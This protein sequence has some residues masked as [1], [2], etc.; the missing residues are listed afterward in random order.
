MK[1]STH[2]TFRSIFTWFLGPAFGALG[3]AMVINKAGTF[4]AFIKF[5]VP[6]FIIFS[7]MGYLVTWVANR[8]KKDLWGLNDPALFNNKKQIV[9]FYVLLGL[10]LNFIMSGIIDYNNKK[11]ML[12]V[13]FIFAILFFFPLLKEF[14]SWLTTKWTQKKKWTV[15]TG[16]V[17]LFG[18]LSSF[19]V[20]LNQLQWG[21]PYGY[22]WDEPNILGLS[23]RMFRDGFISPDQYY[24][25]SFSIY[26]QFIGVHFSY[27]IGKVMGLINSKLDIITNFESPTWYWIISHSLFWYGGRFLHALTSCV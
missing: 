14:Y 19:L 17:L 1:S 11:S 24:Y 7:F 3:V 8:K 27:A 20:R 12:P 22:H 21:L 16:L 13:F 26:Y 18:A 4:S 25:P 10:P 5:W 2:V 15:V 9:W 6:L 23:L